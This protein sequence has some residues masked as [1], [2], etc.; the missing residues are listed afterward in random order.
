MTRHTAELIVVLFLMTLGCGGGED[1]SGNREPGDD[2]DVA[3]TTASPVELEPG[4]P[5]LLRRPF[6]ADEIRDE[7]VEGFRLLIR[8][9]TPAAVKI[10]RWTVISADDEGAEIEY[11]T[12]DENNNVS[13][14][15]VQGTTWVE[16][17]D[18]ASF[19]AATTTREWVTRST[20]LG[21]YEG[22]LYRVT[23]VAGTAIEEYFFVPSLPGAPVEMKIL[24]GDTTV[25]TLE[26]MAR[27][28]PDAP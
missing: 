5:S 9:S 27:L 13:Q 1:P 4:D 22:W 8:R 25:F 14:S 19:P 7:W 26:Q 12:L 6:T 23:G 21:T 28:R 17:R 11:A 2:F 24:D 16:L 10:E 15:A 3:A 18:H 20:G